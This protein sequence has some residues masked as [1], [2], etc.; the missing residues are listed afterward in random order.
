MRI[1]FVLLFFISM[2]VKLFRW[3]RRL[4]YLTLFTRVIF[5]QHILQGR[6]GQKPSYLTPQPN[7]CKHQI[8][9]AAFVQPKFLEKLVLNWLR[10]PSDA[11]D[12]FSKND[13]IFQWRHKRFKFRT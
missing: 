3:I 8:E 13:V 7:S 11:R 4:L 2:I 1:T 12:I 9:Y 5:S 6:G 10:H